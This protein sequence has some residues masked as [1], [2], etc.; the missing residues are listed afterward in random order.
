MNNVQGVINAFFGLPRPG[1]P[2]II[3]EIPQRRTSSL[4]LML[5]FRAG[6]TS[7]C[8]EPS[9][10]LLALIIDPAAWDRLFHLLRREGIIISNRGPIKI[11]GIVQAGARTKRHDDRTAIDVVRS[12]WEYVDDL[13]RPDA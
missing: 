9:C 1:P 7:C 2:A 13:I 4:R 12:Y 6:E 8:S 5:V 3:A 10:H 11:L